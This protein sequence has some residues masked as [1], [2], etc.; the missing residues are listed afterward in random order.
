VDAAVARACGE[1]DERDERET[2]GRGW[3]THDLP[4]AQ[5][6]VVDT[7]RE[8]GKATTVLW[9][10]IVAAAAV[11]SAMAPEQSVVPAPVPAPQFVVVASGECPD[12]EAV[13]AALLPALAGRAPRAVPEPPRVADLGDRFEIAA[14]G[15]TRQYADAAR[16]CAERARVAAVFITLALYPPTLP[17]PPP[18]PP[19]KQPPPATPETPESAAPVSAR[20]A[21]VAIGA[22]LDGSIG[23]SASSLDGV[24]SGAELRG[25]FGWRSLGLGIAA[26]I[27]APTEATL[28]AVTIRQQ[29]FPASLAL[30]LR[31]PLPRGM[32]IAA[33]VGVSLVPFTLRGDGLAAST[34]AT[35]LDTG[36]RLA[37]AIG[38]P[39]LGRH[40]IPFLGL[41]AE[42]FP[43][44]YLLEVDPLGEVGSTGRLWLG[45]SA[46]VALEAR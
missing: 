35:R 22:R 17:S 45:A 30:L 32:E 25:A 27:L 12:R 46:G 34:P 6:R 10:L 33:A 23:G 16:D 20:W 37:M 26:G 3:A 43:R 44:A 39:P 11:A 18:P 28:S 13:M 42:Y 8:I 24:T 31:Q 19:N 38:F 15:Q 7:I 36:A 4:G 21:S 40:A 5:D 41:H 14:F 2:R 29:R 9:D 1:R